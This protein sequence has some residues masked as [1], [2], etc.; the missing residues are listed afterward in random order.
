LD[1]NQTKSSA[2][3]G[4]GSLR[5]PDILAHRFGDERVGLKREAL[6]RKYEK[7]EATFRGI[8]ILDE[9]DWSLFFNSLH[10]PAKAL[11]RKVA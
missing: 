2:T 6:A 10:N 5:H 1:G 3:L 11:L 7:K 9:I 4:Y 8:Q